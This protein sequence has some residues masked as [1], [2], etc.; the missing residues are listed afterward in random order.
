MESRE[1]KIGPPFLE[2]D[3]V[4]VRAGGQPGSVRA[5][6]L[7]RIPGK[8]RKPGK[9]PVSPGEKVGW[10]SALNSVRKAREG[11]ITNFHRRDKVAVDA[12]RS[13]EFLNVVEHDDGT[14]VEAEILDRI[15]DFAVF[16]EEGSVPCKTS[17]EKRLWV[18]RSDIPCARNQYTPAGVGDHFL[19]RRVASL[20]NDVRRPR[21][22]LDSFFAGP[23]S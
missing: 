1:R 5:I 3:R 16:D 2:R 15:L 10:F 18:Y 12:L 17:V 7:M 4:T 21:Y 11:K 14:L 13:T 22:G 19:G 20:D 9:R 6:H 8:V 23:V